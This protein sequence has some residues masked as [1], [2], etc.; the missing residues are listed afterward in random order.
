MKI[1]DEV[2][3]KMTGVS[4]WTAY[5]TSKEQM[6]PNAVLADCGGV[7]LEEN[8]KE[9]LLLGLFPM[10]AKDFLMKI[11]KARYEMSKPAEEPS[12]PVVD[13]SSN[14]AGVSV[15][16]QAVLAPLPGKVLEILVNVGDV[17]K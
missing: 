5:D 2:R 3:Q 4:E 12:A 14:K 11:K 1:V 17:V 6:Q 15:S 7:K 8:E 9:V 16:E 13:T 10:V